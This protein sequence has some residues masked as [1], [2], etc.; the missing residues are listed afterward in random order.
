MILV[1]SKGGAPDHPAW[2]HNLKAQ[3]RVRVQHRGG[4]EERIAHEATGAER[5]ALY[6]R[7]AREFAN[8]TAY[9]QRATAASGRVIPVVVL[10]PIRRSEGKG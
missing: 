1:A 5:D 9:Q 10:E 8:F 2:Y 7:M 3:P 4:I 6:A